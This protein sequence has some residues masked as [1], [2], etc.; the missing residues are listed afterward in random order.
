MTET[1]SSSNVLTKQ[2]KIADLASRKRDVTLETLA[3]HI[4]LDWLREAYRRTRKTGAVGVDGVDAEAYEEHLD[5]NLQSLLNRFKSGVYRAP[6]VRRVHIDKDGG[7]ETRP[8]GIPTLE[9]KVLQRAVLMVLEPVFE[10]DFLDC[11]YGF[12]PGRSAH[13]AL[14]CLRNGLMNL[15]GGWIIDLDIRQFFDKVDRRHLNEMLDQRVVDGDIRRVIGKWMHAGVMEGQVLSYPEL[16]TPQG[17]VVSPLISNVYLHAVLDTWFES[18]VKP[19]LRGRA[20]MVRFADDA[21]LCFEYEE[22]ARRTLAVLPKRFNRFGLELNEAKT[23]L[24][25]F[26]RPS[27]VKIP[28]KDKLSHSAFDFLS[29]THFW[30]RSRKGYWVIKRKTAKKRF[31]RSLKRVSDW[32]RQNRHRAVT[33]QHQ[34]L[35]RK[36]RG[37]Y[38][39]FGITGNSRSLGRF[40]REVERIWRKWLG[41]RSSKA[42]RTW[43]RFHWLS[44]RYPLAPP[45]VIHS[46][47]HPPAKP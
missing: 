46:V 3:H 32:C 10:Q 21:T 27:G 17:G 41:R 13:D 1:P 44:K 35:N 19:R 26:K 34:V 16:G 7:K 20:F 33:E 18:Q 14:E 22:D 5:E 23:K 43:E 24:V 15:G 25:P 45:R 47:Y 36:L 40:H 12:R 9:D 38:A 2:H 4:D 31:G 11:S 29:F 8:I 42:H 39:Y 30:A 28:V 37:H 6:A